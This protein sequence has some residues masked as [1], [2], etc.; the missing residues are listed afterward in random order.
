LTI[1]ESVR[2]Y[3]DSRPGGGPVLLLG[4]VVEHATTLRVHS[5]PLIIVAD[6]YDGTNGSIDARGVNSGA[7]G[8]PGLPVV[9]PGPATTRSPT[10]P[11]GG[12]AAT[13]RSP[14]R[15]P[16]QLIPSSGSLGRS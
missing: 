11:P 4:R 3:Y 8:P 13:G 6:L 5:E 1:D 2:T 10:S 9:T 14:S 12:A 16:P 15:Q 7:V